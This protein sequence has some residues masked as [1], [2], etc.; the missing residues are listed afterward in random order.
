MESIKPNVRV[1]LEVFFAHIRYSNKITS[2][3]VIIGMVAGVI[4]L[5]LTGHPASFRLLLV[6]INQYKWQI[7]S[8]LLLIHFIPVNVYAI[9]KTLNNRYP[10]FR[11]VLI[12]VDE[13]SDETDHRHHQTSQNG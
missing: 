10:R 7:G 9:I 2:L 3:I 8:T 1:A 6:Y 12:P 4:A 11:I 13:N 5:K